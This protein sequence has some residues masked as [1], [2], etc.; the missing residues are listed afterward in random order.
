ML[1]RILKIIVCVLP[2]VLLL[3]AGAA[4]AA[5]RLLTKSDVLELSAG[6]MGD[7]PWAQ[8]HREEALNA[9]RDLIKSTGVDFRY[10]LAFDNEM[11]AQNTADVR[12]NDAIAVNYGSHPTLKAYV[13]TFLVGRFRP[14][15]IREETNGQGVTTYFAADGYE[16][17]GILY[18][19]SDHTFAWDVSGGGKTVVD[20]RWHEAS[21]AE[22]FAYE[23]GPAIVLEQARG[24]YDYTVRVRRQADFEGWL[25]VGQ[26]QARVGSQYANRP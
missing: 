24:G 23:G 18:I 7:D 2:L 22:K 19:G 26:G 1:A 10:S 13:G 5:P 3:T 17:L 25:Q 15:H 8:P 6:L 11:G 12:I 20:G 4:V 9:I 21:E 14:G 16:P